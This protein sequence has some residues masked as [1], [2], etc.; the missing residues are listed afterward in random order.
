MK[1][2]IIVLFSLFALQLRA[3]ED[4]TLGVDMGWLTQYEA[5]GHKFYDRA[6]REREA[7]SLMADY[8]IT[9]ER[10]RVW[11][12]PSAHGNWCG[13]EDVLAKCLRA[14]ELGQDI[15]IDFHYS[16][17]WADPG[18]QNIP[19]AWKGH[20]FRKMKKD[21]AAHTIEI[22]SYLKANGIQP[23]WVQVGN[24]T[25]HGMLWPL[26]KLPEQP[27]Q[28][29]GF[30]RAGYDAVKRVF[31]DAIVIV[32][33]DNGFDN[34]L[35]NYNLD[36]IKRFGGKFDMIGMSLYPYWSIRAN[37]EP[38]AEK[39]ISDCITNINLVS[40]KYGV[41]VMITETGFEVDE[42]HPEKM[43]EGRDL[44][45]M[46]IR[47]LK[48]LTYGH[49]RGV[50]YWEPEC[51][52]S[53]YK[54]GAFTEDGRPT[55]IMNG[56]L[57]QDPEPIIIE[58]TVAAVK[59]TVIDTTRQIYSYADMLE[60]LQVL[61]EIYPDVISYE[62]GD[63]TSQGRRIPIL[64]F[65]GADATRQIMVTGSIH[66]R[67]Y[68][69][70][71]LVMAMVEHYASG[72]DSLQFEG[73]PVKDIFDCIALFIVPMAN[74]DGVEI[75]QRGVEGAVTDEAKRWV[76]EQM[77]EEDYDQIKANANG[78]DINRNFG[79]GFGKG[80][81]ARRQPSFYFYSGPH[82]FSEVETRLLMRVSKQHEYLCFLNY[83]S[84]GNNVFY[85]CKN[86]KKSVNAEA[87]R[88]SNIIKKHT[89]YPLF[90]PNT[91]APCGSWADEVEV[92]YDRPSATIEI[93]TQNPVPIEE[94]QGIFSKNVWV[95][96]DI[97]KSFLNA[98]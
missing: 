22:L 36:I 41:D 75:A 49:C 25:S 86:A 90:G 30:F 74:P 89:D 33:L 81:W 52:P 59:P 8:G 26:G 13:K 48:K 11:V 39:T 4:F 88:I 57:E 23:K 17:W 53:Q 29:A 15:M 14:K 87:L 28:Y 24:E 66:A 40:R 32:H 60:D 70:S 34:K 38:N 21:L 76:A 5:Q 77:Q 56:F 37:R 50:F 10:V 82:A 94:F 16:D 64:R 45:R 92:D 46:M 93:G 83:H 67:E 35:Y 78:V 72:Y 47:K 7:M 61:S 73:V 85:G 18:K 27:K 12:D 79:N 84:K 69:S 96:A 97:C 71:Q 42:Q 2:L 1:T 65:G 98:R 80:R 9:A 3:Q 6:G 95:W 68:M 58:D 63:T 19:A 54:L 91:A 62:F 51:R 43:E 31:P 55:V 44:L 20:S